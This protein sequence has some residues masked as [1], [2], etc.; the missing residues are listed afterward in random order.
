MRGRFRLALLG[1]ILLALLAWTTHM[2]IRNAPEPRYKILDLGPL[3]LSAVFPRAL[4]EEGHIVGMFQ[5]G[6]ESSAFLWTEKDGFTNLSEEAGLLTDSTE[7]QAVALDDS[8]EILLTAK[9]PGEIHLLLR[10]SPSGEIEELHRGPDRCETLGLAGDGKVVATFREMGVN[11]SRTFLWQEGIQGSLISDSSPD[12][13]YCGANGINRAGW[14][15]GR[16]GL[17]E[18]PGAFLLEPGGVPQALSGLDWLS[19][20]IALD[21]NDR[22]QVVGTGPMESDDVKGFLWSK[23]LGGARLEDSEA[24]SVF[25]QALNNAG[26][27][28]GYYRYS[29]WKTKKQRLTLARYATLFG[30]RGPRLRGYARA[31]I[32]EDGKR[33]NLNELI[34]DNPDWDNLYAATD[35]NNSG[36]IIGHGLLRTGESRGFLLTPIGQ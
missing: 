27:I 14:I 18:G 4:N 13:L 23:E 34:P 8:G 3:G 28:V 25:P 22:G 33:F 10:R 32:W 7:S 12:C 20:T 21:I 2:K 31:C 30:M 1:G 26:L 19:D 15:V 17:P 36:R 5:H 35:I 6:T 11:R 16:T 24:L 29:V 9:L